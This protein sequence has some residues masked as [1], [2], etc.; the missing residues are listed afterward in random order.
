MAGVNWQ[1]FG[2]RKNPYDT[3]PLIEGGDVPIEQAFVGREA[4]KHFLDSLFESNDRLCLTICGDVGVGKTSLTNFHK[5]IWKYEREKLL[6]SF[7]REIEASDDLLNKK[8][9]LIEIIG[10]VLRELKLLEPD[11]LKD[12]LMVKLSQIVDISQTMAIS[13]GGAAYGFGLDFGKEKSFVP[14][15]QFSATLLEECFSDLVSFIKSKEINGL[16]YSGL[17]IHVNNFDIVLSKEGGKEKAISFFDEVRD[18]LQTPDVYFIFLGPKSF[19]KDVIVARQRVKSIF[20]PTP[21][22]LNP[23]SKTEIIQAFKERMELLK[24]EDVKAYIKPIDDEVVYKLYDL[25]NGDIRSI[26]SSILDIMNQC[27]EKLAKPLSI[28]EAMLILGKALWERIES[29]MKLTPYTK[30][31]LRYFASTES[32]ISQKEVAEI[33]KKSRS[34]VSGYYFKQLKDNN[35]IEEKERKE[36]IPYYGLTVEYTPLKWLIKSQEGVDESLESKSKQ[37]SFNF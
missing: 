31:I 28:N 17:V 2:L 36:K 4:E 35:I 20:F 14:P 12:P 23:L 19:F 27:S 25:Y 8:N 34:N 37:A 22:N 3:L 21:L 10:S 16:N 1:Q 26:M 6:F 5:V 24:S 11:L 29:A 33:F 9:F 32:Y 18:I 7:R 15:M 30:E 13:I